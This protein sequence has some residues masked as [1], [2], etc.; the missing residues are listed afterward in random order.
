MSHNVNLTVV[1]TIVEA[2]TLIKGV[3]EKLIFS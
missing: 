1:E 3:G 2:L